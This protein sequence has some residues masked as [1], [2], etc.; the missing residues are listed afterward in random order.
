M[1]STNGRAVPRPSSR[2]CAGRSAPRPRFWSTPIAASLRPAPSRVGKLLAAEGVEHFEE[3]CLYWELEHTRQVS[4]AL[5]I[6]VTGGE[7]TI[8]ISSIW[9]VI[10]GQR[11]VEHIAQPDVLYVGGIGRALKVARLAETAGLKVTPHAA[12]LG[13]VTL[14][15]MHLLAAVPNAGKYLRIL[16]RGSVYWTDYRAGNTAS[17]ATIPIGSRTAM[18]PSRRSRVGA[19]R[20]SRNGLSPNPAIRSASKAESLSPRALDLRCSQSGSQ[21]L[22]PDTFPESFYTYWGSWAVCSEQADL[23]PVFA[24]GPLSIIP[25][26]LAARASRGKGLAISSMPGSRKRVREAAPSA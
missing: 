17:F 20:S 26:I 1:T 21:P 8:A 16:H 12:N 2:R 23:H 24:G 6:A 9:R 7:Q 15:T 22:D 25:R 18:S 3:P 11:I 19:S 13:L 5:D 10:C 4:E 14:F